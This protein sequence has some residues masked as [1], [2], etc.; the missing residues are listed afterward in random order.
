MQIQNVLKTLIAGCLLATTL[1]F[2]SCMNLFQAVAFPNQC[3]KCTVYHR[4]EVVYV[5]EGCGASNVRIEEEAK[6]AAYDLS[7]GCGLGNYD[8]RCE[9]WRVDPEPTTP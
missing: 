8:V 4:S 7:R 3:K 2:T 5:T 9:T 1:F 6:V